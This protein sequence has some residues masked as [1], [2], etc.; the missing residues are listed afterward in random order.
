[1]RF[2]V[3]AS[4]IKQQAREEGF[5]GFVAPV[6]AEQKPA[7]VVEP[8]EGAFDDPAVASDAGAAQGSLRWGQRRRPQSG[9]SLEHCEVANGI[10]LVREQDR[11]LKQVVGHVGVV[12]APHRP[13][14]PA[15]DAVDGCRVPA[16]GEGKLDRNPCERPKEL[17]VVPRRR[18]AIS[19]IEVERIRLELPTVRDIV[20]VG[21]MAY[22]GLRPGEALAMTMGYRP[23][24]S[25]RRCLTAGTG[26]DDRRDG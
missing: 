2:R 11:L 10:V 13:S 9:D 24:A 15:E 8:G 19:P 1:M 12:A 22:A 26:F 7:A 21:L 6:G 18:R 17:P 16:V 25:L 20:L 3:G 5:V 14:R 4:S 23:A